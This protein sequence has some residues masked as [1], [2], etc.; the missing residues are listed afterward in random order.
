VL[1]RKSALLSECAGV[2]AAAGCAVF[3]KWDQPNSTGMTIPPPILQLLLLIG[4]GFF[5][6]LAF[7]EFHARTNQKRPG[8][9]RSFPLLALAGALLYR[10]DPTHLLPLSVG[11]LALSGWLTCYYW[12]HLDETDAEGFPNVG[13]MVPICNVLAYLLGPVTL[14]EPP[15]VAIG[16]TV[17]AVLFLTAREGLHG[18]ARRLELGEIVTAGRFLLLTGFVLPLLPDTPVTDLTSITPHQVWLAMVAVCTVSYA[19][20]L[21]QRYVT[22]F[23]A[24]LLTAVVGGFYSSTATTVVLARRV[25]AELTTTRQAQTGI[26]LATAVMYLRLLI[27]IAVF[28]PPLA[29]AVAPALLILSV[30]GL[31]AAAGAYWTGHSQQHDKISTGA[32]TNPLELG[33]AAVFAVLFIA[34]SVASSWAALRF[35]TAG[36]YVLAVIVGVSDIDPFVLSLAQHGA[37]EISSSVGVIAI[38]L[39]TSS[40]NLLKAVYVVAFS[41]GRLRTW[42]VATLALLAACGIGVAVALV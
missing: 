27:I 24:G 19:S 36:I 39:A 14:A 23:S 31:L 12:R 20:Y 1:A 16:S 22:P 37:G 3:D 11:L 25:R 28:N 29:F 21:L 26:I 7:E 17:A 18:F 6:G 32:P 5:L 30:L 34:I 35:G 40:N 10:L 33:A 41:G 9:V 38:L 2:P 13:L 15:W 8:G 4:L 42:P